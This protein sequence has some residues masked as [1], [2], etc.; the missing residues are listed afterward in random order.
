MK[1][2]GLDKRHRNKDG[3]ISG[4]HGNTLNRNLP[5]PIDGFGPNVSLAEMREKTGETSEKAIRAA[6]ARK[7][8][9]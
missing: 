8:K 2:P 6:V 9:R 3:T 1:E 7:K 4:K 5:T